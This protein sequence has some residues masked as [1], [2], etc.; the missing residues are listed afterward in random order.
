MYVIG[1]AKITQDKV[2]RFQRLESIAVIAVQIKVKGIC[3]MCQFVFSCFNFDNFFL[4]N[5]QNLFSW[6][7]FE[8][9]GWLFCTR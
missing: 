4:Q 3:D 7:F 1:G 8:C 6:P 2:I 5:S 9:F